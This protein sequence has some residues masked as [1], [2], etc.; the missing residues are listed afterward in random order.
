M[1]AL[2]GELAGAA[3]VLDR[4]DELARLADAVEAEH[5]D[6]HP[7][8]GALHPVADEVVHR[9]HPAPLR[10]GDQRVADL[11]RAALDQDA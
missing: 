3:V 9:P 1:R 7:G 4:V 8:P 2:L 5:L 6:R 11:Q 10:A